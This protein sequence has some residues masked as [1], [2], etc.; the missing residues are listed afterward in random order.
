[1]DNLYLGTAGWSY[2]DWVGSFYPPGT[3]SSA[4]LSEYSRQFRAVE[5]DSTF[6]GTPRPET[7]LRW[8]EATPPGF[9]FC[10]KMVRTVTHDKRLIGAEEETEAFL[11]TLGVLGPKLGPIVLQFDYTFGP[12]Q[13]EPL[14]HYLRSLPDGVRFAVELRHRGWLRNDTYRLLADAGVAL[15]LHDLHYMPRISV[16][17]TDFTYVRWLGRRADVE[18][19]DRVVRDRT[20]ELSWWAERAREWLNR[21]VRV[22]AFANNRYQGHGP[23][24]AAAF[25][26]QMRLLIPPA[27][28]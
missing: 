23:A 10:P 13:A 12:D 6:Y 14:R 20:R 17:T 16:V 7:V 3:P 1:L 28:G 4:F 5:V 27:E 2:A 11:T 19:F 26:E 22:Y 18:R 9:L 15:V 24:T 8:T 21:G 25:L